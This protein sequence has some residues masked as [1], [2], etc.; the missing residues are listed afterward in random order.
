MGKTDFQFTDSD[1]QDFIRCGYVILTPDYPPKLHQTIQ[2]KTDLA[3]ESGDPGNRI[4]Q[5]VPELQQVFNHPDVHQT[6][7]LAILLA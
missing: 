4:L 5:Q 6:V 7:L 1:L 3:F 2:R